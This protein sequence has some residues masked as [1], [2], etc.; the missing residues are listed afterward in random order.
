MENCYY[1]GWIHTSSV[2]IPTL[3]AMINV[4]SM[5]LS[6]VILLILSARTAPHKNSLLFIMLALFT[7]VHGLWHLT[8]YIGERG[9][10]GFLGPASA[11]LLLLFTI[12]YFRRW[13]STAG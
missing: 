3:G 5:F 2:D 1:W 10:A 7:L 4:G 6:T 12:L 11:V 13:F 8:L 9:A